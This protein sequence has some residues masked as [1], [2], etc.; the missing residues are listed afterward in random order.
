MKT[1]EIVQIIGAVVDVKFPYDCMPNIFDALEL[2]EDTV[3]GLI[4]EV[5]QTLGGG[6]VRTIS[7]GTSD[8][9]TLKMSALNT[10]KPINKPVSVI[11][12]SSFLK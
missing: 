5:Q 11:N 12:F 10:G 7:I 8:K 1:G 4:L 6:I 9:L 3:K 2:N